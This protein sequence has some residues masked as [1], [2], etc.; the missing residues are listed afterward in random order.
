ML[1]AKPQVSSARTEDQDTIDLLEG[2]V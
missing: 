1:Q 2:F